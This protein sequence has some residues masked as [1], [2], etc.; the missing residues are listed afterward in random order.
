M[1]DVRVCFLAILAATILAAS[2]CDRNVNDD[3][4]QKK[5]VEVVMP[6]GLSKGASQEDYNKYIQEKM[7]PGSRGA[8]GYPGAA[9][10]PKKAGAVATTK[11]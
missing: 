2:G 1:K 3:D 10:A 4:L 9:K 6:E 5:N 11:K 8:A 7:K